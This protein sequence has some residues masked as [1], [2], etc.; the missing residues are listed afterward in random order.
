MT[1]KDPSTFIFSCD[2]VLEAKR[3]IVFLKMTHALGVSLARPSNESF[4]RYSKL[5][6]PLVAT[7]LHK[8]DKHSKHICLIPPPD[9]AWLWHCHRLAPFHYAHYVKQHFPN[10][11]EGELLDDATAPFALQV[12]SA[13]ICHS[14]PLL[15]QSDATGNFHWI[16]DSSQKDVEETRRLWG[17]VY[18]NEPFFSMSSLQNEH[19]PPLNNVNR[20]LK[21]ASGLANEYNVQDAAERQAVFLWQVHGGQYLEDSFL[22][23]GAQNYGKFIQLKSTEAGKK[24]LIVPTCQIDLLWHTHILF[25]ISKYNNDCLCIAGC[26]IHHDDSL[27][28]RCEGGLLDI[29]FQATQQLWRETYG[30]SYTVKGAMYPGQPPAAYFHAQW[31]LHP[32]LMWTLPREK[33]FK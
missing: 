32:V 3:H 11:E 9:V 28:D 13:S 27:D 29:N 17:E 5:W 14:L 10:L 21:E 19:Q 23:Q 15:F 25:S 22:R 6:L 16:N 2:L 26:E 20:G 12:D 4:R 8:D 31:V 7:Q 1:I 30:L 33:N 18:P 24:I